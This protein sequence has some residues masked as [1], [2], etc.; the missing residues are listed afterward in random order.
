MFYNG[1]FQNGF[2]N[3]RFA[4]VLGQIGLAYLFASLIV[5]YTKSF[6]QRLYWLAG[7]LIGY[8]L[9]QL[10]VPVPG[11]G[12]GVLTP[13]GCIN[14]YI[15]RLLL[16]GRLYGGVYDPEGLLCVVS[17]T[18]ITLMELRKYFTDRKTTKQEGAQAFGHWTVAC[19][20]PY[21]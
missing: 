17:A 7:I 4:S 6:R 8:S 15:D 13:E 19:W 10:L 14:G 2:E 20:W 1:V 21:C 5:L 3:P 11:F 9:I 12:A 18:G 16:P